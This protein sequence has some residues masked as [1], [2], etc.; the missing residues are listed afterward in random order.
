MPDHQTSPSA[1]P[2]GQW[3]VAGGAMG[4]QVRAFDWSA[5]PLGPIAH[6]PESLKIAVGICLSSRFPMFVWWGPHLIN[7]YNDAYIPML[8]KR[9]PAA[10]G[11]P[12]R[13]SWDDIWDVVGK[14]ADLVTRLGQATWNE[15]V[16]LVME[17][18]GY[19]EETFFTWSYSPIRD[20]AGQVRGLFCAVT[21]ET[22]RVR[23]EAALRHSEARFQAFMDHSPTASWITDADGR[24]EYCSGTYVRA[25]A[26]ATHDVVGRTPAELYPPEFA[27]QYVAN[28]RAVA[29][30]GR[31]IE[32][33][34]S[35]PRPDGSV[36][37]F[38]VYKFPL[39]DATGRTLVGGVAVDVTD[40]KRAQRD[41]DQLLLAERAARAEAE[42]A[43]RL[44][45]DF[46]TTLS[47]ELRTPL[48]AIVGWSHLLERGHADPQMLAEG[49]S[50]I[51]RNARA[52]TQLI[53][54][55]LDM[56]RIVTGK[57]RLEHRPLAPAAVVLAALESVRPAAQAKGV[58]LEHA[59]DP[60]SGPVAGDPHRL[61]Q[62]VWNLLT[63]AIK[64]TPA[65]GTVRVTLA[66][67]GPN[68]ELA[69]ADTG[70][71]IRPEFLPHLFERFRQADGSTT[72]RHGG[73][74][75]GLAL[76]K[77]I[78][79]LHGGDVRATSPGQGQGATF[80][81]TLPAIPEP[82]PDLDAD[83][84]GLHPAPA[85][86][87]DQPAAHFTLPAVSLADLR[88]LLV[89][90]DPDSVTIARAVLLDRGGSVTVASSA[91]EALDL[92][93]RD[94]PDVLVSDIGMPGHDG[95]QLIRWVRA[96]P[97]DQ[98]GRTPAVALTAFARPDDR[99]RA[100]V[101]GYQSHVV[102][103]VHPEELVAVIASLTH[104]VGTLSQME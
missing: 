56:S 71:G 52:Q 88:I 96:L 17:R 30:S 20:D 14:Q 38:I 40:R 79:H 7:I 24:I 48:N 66:F 5:T 27:E 34:E 1:P 11:R 15:R 91:A 51:A 67:A 45:D 59:L 78:V 47:H 77:E 10:L 9:H 100:L 80:V 68:L 33:E 94:R 53:E 12:A 90:D 36:G 37:E 69:V 2:D 3:L 93:R 70:Q 99:R 74:G 32:V 8:G 29:Q 63:N 76:V 23:A 103:P 86:A 58:H 16:R 97:P 82:R 46:L 22:E 98:G 26:L 42:R 60:A 84:V 65:G 50:A 4:D 87:A 43:S 73:L 6:W 44:K 21:E 54:D 64:F 95:Y 62:A 35:A 92:L 13:D 102:K 31:A 101:A 104:R 85:N 25:F 72:R 49:L 81:I 39:T 57:L 61:Q 83:A 75:I 28:I 89:D 41:R 55:L 18:K 19:A